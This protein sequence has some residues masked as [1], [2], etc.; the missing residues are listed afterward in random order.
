MVHYRGRGQSPDCLAAHT[1]GVAVQVGFP[2]QLPPVIV[3]LLFGA[4]AVFVVERGVVLTV[5]RPIWDE[6]RT[7]GVLARRAWSMRHEVDLLSMYQAGKDKSR[8]DKSSG[9]GLSQSHGPLRV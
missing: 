7:S 2:C 8:P 6:P 9:P 3:A 5:H 1:Q 4:L